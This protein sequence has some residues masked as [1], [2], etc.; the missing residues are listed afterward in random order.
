MANLSFVK[1]LKNSLPPFATQKQLV[2]EAEKEEE[3]I[4]ANKKLMKL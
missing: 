4:N 2:A 1:K 3:I